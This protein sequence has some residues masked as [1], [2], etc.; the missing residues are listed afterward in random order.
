M[1]SP[2]H[3]EQQLHDVEDAVVYT[4]LYPCELCQKYLRDC[5]AEKVVVFGKDRPE[6]NFGHIPIEV[7]LNVF[8]F[9]KEYNN[10]IQ[11]EDVAISEMAELTK[12]IMDLRREDREESVATLINNKEEEK[13]D[14][15]IQSM[16]LKDYDF[17][18]YW[19]LKLKKLEDRINNGTFN[20]S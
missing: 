13:I 17:S 8:T 12:V 9:L 3:A 2:I 6:W 7:R 15:M 4:N 5:G 18:F 1:C 11:Q 19:D 14:V 16:L 10:K 20:R